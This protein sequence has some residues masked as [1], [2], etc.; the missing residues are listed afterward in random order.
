MEKSVFVNEGMPGPMNRL[1]A[2]TVALIYLQEMHDARKRLG[3]TEE[4]S[5]SMRELRESV[6]ILSA[7]HGIAAAETTLGSLERSHGVTAYT[8][9]LNKGA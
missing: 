3:E 6:D 5:V 2:L 8:E 7:L 4:R 9:G 1:R